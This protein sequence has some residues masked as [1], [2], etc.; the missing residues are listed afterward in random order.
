[1]KINEIKKNTRMLFL[2]QVHRFY[3]KKYIHIFI[4]IN[5]VY[6][7]VPGTIL[8]LRLSVLPF[9]FKINFLKCFFFY[10]KHHHLTFINIIKYE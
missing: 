9:G 6:V 7:P 3:F 2:V 4:Y 5:K 10:E 1:M 8:S